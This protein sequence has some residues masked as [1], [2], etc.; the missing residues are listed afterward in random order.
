M[1]YEA[2]AKVLVHWVDIVSW[3]GWNQELIDKML[4]DRKRRYEREEYLRELEAI[5]LEE[6]SDDEEDD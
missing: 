1:I 2:G 4:R 6:N 3:S 5:K